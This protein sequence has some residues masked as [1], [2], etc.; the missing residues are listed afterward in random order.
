MTTKQISVALHALRPDEE[1]SFSGNDYSTVVWHS[2]GLSAPT[3]AE[4][5]AKVAELGE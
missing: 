2:Q 5:E 4:V 1:W 3:L